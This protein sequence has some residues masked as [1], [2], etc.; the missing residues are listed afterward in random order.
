MGPLFIEIIF[1][2]FL[3]K[4]KNILTGNRFVSYW[5]CN[6]NGFARNS[7][8]HIFLLSI[9]RLNTYRPKQ[10]QRQ[11]FIYLLPDRSQKYLAISA[12]VSSQREEKSKWFVGFVII[13]GCR[14]FLLVSSSSCT[15]DEEQNRKNFPKQK[16]IIRPHRDV[17]AISYISWTLHFYVCLKWKRRIG[18]RTNERTNE[19]PSL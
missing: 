17:A 15:V 5:R 4:F 11:S 19:P 1:F 13:Y 18:H 10:T 6:K 3:R 12:W 14:I 8:H 9:L 16:K 7:V 2:F